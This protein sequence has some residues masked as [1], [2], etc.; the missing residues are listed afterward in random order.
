MALRITPHSTKVLFA[1]AAPS[2]SRH[3]PHPQSPTSPGNEHAPP[4]SEAFQTPHLK[5]SIGSLPCPIMIH[6]LV[7][8]IILHVFPVVQ[9]TATEILLGWKLNPHGSEPSGSEPELKVSADK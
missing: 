4:P 5:A 1:P 3:A 8:I 7:C 2:D 9:I 6:V